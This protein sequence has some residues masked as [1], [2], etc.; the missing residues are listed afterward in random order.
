[1][2]SEMCIRDRDGIAYI[3][4]YD[5]GGTTITLPSGAG[6][7]GQV[8]TTNGSSA[9]SWSDVSANVVTASA[10]NSTDET[11]YITFLDGATGSQGI[12]TDTGLQYNPSDGKLTSTTF[13]G[14]VVVPDAGTVGSASSTSAMTIASNGIVTFVDD[15]KLKNDGTIGSAGAATAMTISSGGIVTF[16]DDISCLLYTSPSPRDS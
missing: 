11:T 8:L 3:D 13:A 7:N 9:L 10:N 1:M 2:G 14:N 5:F 16:V 4:G 12:E 15:I 6:S